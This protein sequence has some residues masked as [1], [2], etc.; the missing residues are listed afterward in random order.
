M[1]F[2]DKL[3]EGF[4]IVELVESKSD[5]Q[6]RLEDIYS[7]LTMDL[8]TECKF[9]LENY[10]VVTIEIPSPKGYGVAISLLG[11][12]TFLDNLRTL[13]EDYSIDITGDVIPIGSDLGELLYLYGTGNEGVGLYLAFDGDLDKNEYVKLADSISDFFCKGI[14]IDKLI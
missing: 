7:I 6:K 14:G 10:E 5:D 3:C 4:K 11:T 1:N 9:I 2:L 13:K 8:P 12:Y